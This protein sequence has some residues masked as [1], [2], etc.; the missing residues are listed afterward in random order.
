MFG[1]IVM[2]VPR[3]HFEAILKHKKTEVGVTHETHL[4]AR[5]L[6]ELVASFKPLVK[7]ETKKHFPDEPLDQLRMAI[8][9]VFSSWFGAGR[10]NKWIR[11]SYQLTDWLVEPLRR[12]LPPFGMFDLSPLAAYFVLWMLRRLLMGAIL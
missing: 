3:E 4:D 11:W 10:Y 1:S 9:A 12:A 2:G 5:H 8:N 7:E 6:R